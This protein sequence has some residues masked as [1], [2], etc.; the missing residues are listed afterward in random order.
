M[1]KENL[2]VKNNAII[3]VSVKIDFKSPQPPLI[4]GGRG[5]FQGSRGVWCPHHE[6]LSYYPLSPLLPE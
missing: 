6:K 2:S 3:I 4:K 5:D 1:S